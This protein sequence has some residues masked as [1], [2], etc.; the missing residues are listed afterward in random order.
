MRRMMMKTMVTLTMLA[1]PL[2][3]ASRVGA[4]QADNWHV[5]NGVEAPVGFFP[6]MLGVTTAVYLLDPAACPDATDKSLLPNG[7]NGQFLRAGVCMTS[8][9][10]IQLRSAPV[11]SQA[12]ASFTF[13]STSG[14]FST[15]Y[16][17]TPRG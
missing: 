13:W 3:G 14:G 2:A 8:S 15:Y 12:P 7:L 11:G 4:D 10:V 6:G 17:L 9:V 16:K 1:V 5:H